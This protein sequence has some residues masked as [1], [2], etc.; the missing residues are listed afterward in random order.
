[1]LDFENN[2][3]ISPLVKQKF[4]LYNV[5][6]FDTETLRY[7]SGDVEKQVFF[8]CDF[9]DGI[10]HK[11]STNLDDV[12]NII[13]YF[14][15][16]YDKITF[17]SHNIVFDLRVLHLINLVIS[18]KFMGLH[19]KIRILD[20]V[21]YVKF[22]SANHYK[23]IQFFD[24]VNIFQTKLE[25]LGIM[26]GIPKVNT[27]EYDLEPEE[28]N[29]ILK[30]DGQER[31]KKDCEILYVAMQSIR[32]FA[33]FSFAIT[34]ASSSFNTF[35]THHLNTIIEFPKS[36][37]DIAL[38]SYHGGVVMPYKIERGKFLYSYDINSLYPFVMKNEPYS[39]KLIKKRTDKK[40]L[41]DDIRD[42]AYNYLILTTYNANEIKYSP[43]Y[44]NYDNQLMPLLENK[45]W[46][47]GNELLELYD[48][49]FTI[50][51][52][53]IYEFKNEF[54]F[55]DF[56][57]I[58]YEKKNNAKS[59]FEK[60]FYK[61]ILNS[62]YGKFGQH[63]AHSE[64]HKIDEIDDLMIQDII[65]NTTKD[66]VMINDKYY[67]IYG[68]FI[69]VKSE[70]NV[71]YNPLIASEI[72]ANARLINYRYSKMIGFNHLSYTDT[73]SFFVD[74]K[75]DLLVGNDLGKLKNDKYGLFNI[76]APKD[77]EY[78]GIC[79]KKDCPVCKG[80]EEGLHY[81]VKGVND[82]DTIN[83]NKYTIK[84]W[85][86]LKYKDNE[87]IYVTYKEQY[88]NRINKKM[89]YIDGIGY[90]WLNKKEYEMYMP[91]ADAILSL[92]TI[93]NKK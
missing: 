22:E 24:S 4:S 58:Y 47:T 38:E 73:D 36:M 28:W 64:I 63:K 37:I 72:T 79:N 48:N 61:I 46:I 15:K 67:S 50:G 80:K 10:E 84:K 18:E 29:N 19:A 49:N 35:R 14:V 51:I 6:T 74:I 76:Y 23:V 34:I 82:F 2:L 88:L 11:Y 8:N 52:E 43:V 32:N 33:N 78:Y 60:Y 93:K 55:K 68:D 87:D 26:F 27:E 83:E 30:I 81:V 57:D 62:L 40:Y 21:F 66:R 70:E 7:R 86:K 75:L 44:T 41:I 1:M 16:K 45:Q 12:Y 92:P 42:K 90:E 71:K 9:Y 65:K 69:S 91:K 89:K 5:I 25:N 54:L 56:V 17:I 31:V 77:Y 13:S 39:V 3:I 85:S 59:E 53:E 20:R